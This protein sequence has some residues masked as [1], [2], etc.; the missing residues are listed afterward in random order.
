VKRAILVLLIPFV[1]W[2]IERFCHQ[3]TDGF[4]LLR[5]RSSLKPHKEWETQPLTLAE[6]TELSSLLKQPF[7]YYGKGAQ[8]FVFLS[9]DERVVLKLFRNYRMRPPVWSHCLPAFV[10]KEKN[11][12]REWLLHQDFTSYVLAFE[13]LKEETGLLFVHLNKSDDLKQRVTLID[14]LG[15]SHVIDLD[16]MEFLVQKKASL[17]PHTLDRLMKKGEIAQ[18]Q[19]AIDALLELLIIR[20]RRGLFDKDPDLLT[21][22]GFCQGKAIQIDVG[23]FR[24]DLIRKEKA[25]YKDDLIRI[26]DPF[27]HWLTAHYPILADYLDEK[28]QMYSS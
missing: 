18:A 22:F 20:C 26:S 11:R 2:G 7:T 10:S 21:N 16:Q 12:R 8:A 3:K 5:V 19:K 27:K 28:V 1:I 14:K 17:V 25:V 24:R 6:K 15:I 4:S 9:Q 13:E 23:R